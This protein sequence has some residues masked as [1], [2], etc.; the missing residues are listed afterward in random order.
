MC[1]ALQLQSVNIGEMSKQ[2]MCWKGMFAQIVHV[3]RRPVP[4]PG[5]YF[6]CPLSLGDQSP[7]SLSCDE[8]QWK[9]DLHNDSM[10]GGKADP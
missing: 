7:A 1:K 6:P 8:A 4:A 10:G 2:Q 3:K 5:S 9:M